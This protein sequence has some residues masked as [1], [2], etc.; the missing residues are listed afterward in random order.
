[1]VDTHEPSRRRILTGRIL[2]GLAILFLVFDGA[3]KL[4]RPEPVVSATLALGYPEWAI[5]VLGVLL[6]ASVLVHL[7]PRTAILGA[8]LV[9]GYLGGAIAAQV[10]VANPLFSHVLFPAYLALLVWGGL[11]LRDARARALLAAR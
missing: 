4:A 5:P 11:Y 7:V 3:G 9:T 2:S 1:M 8:I 10:R 6:L